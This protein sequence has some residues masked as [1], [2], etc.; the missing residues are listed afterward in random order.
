MA[1]Q[2]PAARPGDT[3]LPTG[4]VTFLFTDIAGSTRL[5]RLDQEAYAAALA[6]HRQLLRAA[7]TAHGGREVDTQGD[8]FFVAFPT[9]GQAVA[10]AAQAQRSLAAHPWPDGGPVPVRMGLHTGEATLG[11]D[12][13]VGLAVHRA[14]RIAAVA[15]GGQVLLSDASAALVGEQL[16]DGLSLRFLGAHPLKDFPQPAPLYQLDIAGLPTAFPP[17]RTPARSRALPAPVGELLGRDG[18]VAALATLLTEPRTRLVTVTGPGGIGKTRL[19]LETARSVAGD[20][21]GGVVF[22]AL[23]AVAD[24]ALVLSTVAEAVGAPPELGVDPVD[25]VR[26]ALGDG[27]TLLVLDNVEQVAAAAPDLAT[28]LDRAPGAVVLATSRRALRLRSERLF[29]LSQ[30]PGPAA[31]RLFAERAA[32]VRPGFRID[33]G[34]AA[35]VAEICRRLDGLPL[36]I[37]LAA[38]RVRLLP[39]TALLARLGE[40]LDVLGGPV[41]LPERQR[42]LRATMDWSFALLGPHEQAVFA[43]LGVFSGGWTLEAAELVCGRPD[44]PDVLG[45]LSDLLDASLVVEIDDTPGEPRLGMLETVRAYAVE[46]LA[47][48]PDRAETERRHTAWVQ[49]LT[50]PV[51]PAVAGGFRDVLERLDRERANLRAAVQRAVDAGDAE[52]VAAL[53]RSASPYL[54]RRDAEREAAGWLDGVLPRAGDA[55]PDVRGRLLAFR[56]IIAGI[57]GDVAVLRRSLE[58]ARSLLRDDA[59]HALEQALLA[60]AD[61]FAALVD[62]SVEEA[63]RKVEEAVTRFTALGR[64]LALGRM[65]MLRGNLALL[66]GNL[67]DAE[68][69]YA[70]AVEVAGRLADDAVLGQALSLSGLVQVV[71]GDLPGGRRAILAAAADSRASGQPSRVAASLEGLAAVALAGG[72]P[73]VAARALAAAAAARSRVAAM[74]FPAVAPLVADLTA[75]ASEQLGEPAYARAAEEGRAWPLLHALDRTLEDLADGDPGSV[76]PG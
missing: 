36:A 76:A 49:A 13:Y 46:K 66:G 64:S 50:A 29:P 16:P 65:N 40:R 75:R 2:P 73:A 38:A 10:A 34:N 37:E 26:A 56:A 69:H 67:A 74:L 24:P 25:A 15:S 27:H 28:L 60:Y 70:E 59:D 54:S 68:Q 42:T 8:S 20:F 41:D 18:Q 52:T 44:E 11:P 22:V 30:L 63:S 71:R 35:A 21:P 51:L 62:G 23:S 31:E 53:V 72:R 5:L 1:E 12:G 17:L 58:G 3:A 48:A 14:A 55:P 6:D 45:A 19:A 43:R 61:V 32:A 47:A 33:A 4:T 39:P 7:F 9:A 57:L